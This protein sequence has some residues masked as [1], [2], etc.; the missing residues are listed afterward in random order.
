VRPTQRQCNAYTGWCHCKVVFTPSAVQELTSVEWCSQWHHLAC[1]RCCWYPVC[2]RTLW[3]WQTT[4][5]TSRRA[6][7]NP[8]AGWTFTGWDVTV[9]SPLAASHEQPLQTLAE[10][11][12]WPA[13][14]WEII[15]SAPWAFVSPYR[16]WKSQ[17]VQF[18]N[19]ELPYV[20]YLM[21]SWTFTHSGQ[22]RPHN[23]T[24]T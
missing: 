19:F 24:H 3:T 18:I 17:I 2:Q 11:L 6:N 22:L 12:I 9:V 5:K 23:H 16:C 4:W 15:D 1:L 8:L 10:W 20:A 13:S 14:Y 7:V 21:V